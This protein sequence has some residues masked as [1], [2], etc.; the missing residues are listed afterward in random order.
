MFV[1]EFTGTGSGGVLTKDFAE[2]GEGRSG[3]CAW[4]CIFRNRGFTPGS[5]DKIEKVLITKK[6]KR[7]KKGYDKADASARVRRELKI[8]APTLD[9]PTVLPHQKTGP[10]RLALR[11]GDKHCPVC[12]ASLPVTGQGGRRV[13]GCPSCGAT[14]RPDRR[15]YRC[16]PGRVWQGKNGVYCQA[17]GRPVGRTE[18]G[19]L[20]ADA[21]VR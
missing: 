21:Q 12:C 16:S 20:K 11:K 9:E 7:S 8:V 18:T 2:R 3:Q 5:K 13:N 10:D 15:C 19:L 17:C 6:H 14:Y 1:S 4:K